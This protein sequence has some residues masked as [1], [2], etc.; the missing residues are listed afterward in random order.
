MHMCTCRFALEFVVYTEAL[1][2]SCCFLGAGGG[3]QDMVEAGHLIQWHRGHP[4]KAAWQAKPPMFILGSCTWSAGIRELRA[5]AAA[6]TF[7]RPKVSFPEGPSTR[8]L[9]TL[10]PKAI[11]GMAFGTSV[12]KYW[13]L[14]PWACFHVYS[15]GLRVLQPGPEPEN[16]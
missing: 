4:N 12:F 15:V 9:R 16:K 8:S 10:V 3:W 7:Q 13:L 5:P 14:G 2:L 11:N 1:L 6:S